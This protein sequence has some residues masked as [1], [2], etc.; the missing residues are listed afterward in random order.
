MQYRTHSQQVRPQD[1]G[2][3][4]TRVVAAE[5]QAEEVIGAGLPE[6]QHAGGDSDGGQVEVLGLAAAHPDLV[7]QGV[8]DHRVTVLAKDAGRKRQGEEF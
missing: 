2:N 1:H 3:L 6:A 5:V 7:P 4:F 8:V